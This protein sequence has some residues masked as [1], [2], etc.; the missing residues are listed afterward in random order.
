[1]TQREPYD[2]PSNTQ[3]GQRALDEI[4]DEIADEITN[5][6]IYSWEQSFASF[7]P[8][9]SLF[10]MG[11]I[12]HQL[13]KTVYAWITLQQ[14]SFHYQSI[15]NQVWIQTLEKLLQELASSEDSN[16]THSGKTNSNN[17]AQTWQQ[18][19]QVWSRLFDQTFTQAF[20]STEA[21]HIQAQ[22]LNAALDYRLQQRQLAEL[23]LEIYDLP[24][25]R[26]IDEIHHSIYEL[27][28]AV[29]AL[30]TR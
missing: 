23:I 17:K 25:R 29:K 24:T 13:L 26:E 10:N 11:S 16:H 4:A 30:K 12:G 14:A 20:R 7:L 18:L 19:L 27:R 28:K 8:G 5:R 9:F 15:Q 1:M 3:S 6:S 22:F 2:C 21:L